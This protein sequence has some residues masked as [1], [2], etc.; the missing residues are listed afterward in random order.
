MRRRIMTICGAVF[1]ACNGATFLLWTYYGN[2]LPHTFDPGAGRTH[3][4]NTHGSIAYLTSVEFYL[5]IGFIA[6]AALSFL[7]MAVAYATDK[8]QSPWDDC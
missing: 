7:I 5:L 4:L 6:G 3:A 2:N 8:G 1:L